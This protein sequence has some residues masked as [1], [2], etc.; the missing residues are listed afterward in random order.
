MQFFKLLVAM[1]AMVSAQHDA[2]K[3]E[4]TSLGTD[5]C[6][7][8]FEDWADCADKYVAVYVESEK[9][10]RSEAG[11]S[12]MSKFYC[13]P[14]TEAD[15][16]KISSDIEE[17]DFSAVSGSA[18]AAGAGILT[19]ILLWVLSPIIICVCICVCCCACNKTCCFAPKPQQIVMQGAGQQPQMMAPKWFIIKLILKIKN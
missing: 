19:I 2:S 16:S 14:P 11:S 3:C 4:G 9:C 13:N 15:L 18:K 8:N 6:C 10:S 5:P 12:M 7:A 17:I 1:S